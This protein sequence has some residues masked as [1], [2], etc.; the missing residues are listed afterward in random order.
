MKVVKVVSLSLI[1]DSQPSE[2]HSKRAFKRTFVYLDRKETK[3]PTGKRLEELKA[4]KRV[5]DISFTR[6]HS[7]L[8]IGRLLLAT[9]PSLLGVDLDR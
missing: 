5:E 2:I 7:A 6:N 1:M 3:A 4:S 8:A 9:F